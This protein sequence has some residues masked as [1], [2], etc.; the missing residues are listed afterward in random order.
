MERVE[1]GGRGRESVE[2]GGGWKNEEVVIRWCGYCK[3]LFLNIVNSLI[4]VNVSGS[5]LVI[6]EVVGE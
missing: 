1:E 3:F 4:G 5:I 2:N 6:F